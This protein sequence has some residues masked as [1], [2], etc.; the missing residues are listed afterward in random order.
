[1]IESH[2]S[3]QEPQRYVRAEPRSSS[4][5]NRMKNGTIHNPGCFPAEKLVTIVECANVAFPS[6]IIRTTQLSGVILFKVR[7]KMS[8]EGGTEEEKGS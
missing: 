7:K 5:C 8:E 3:T 1:M 6:S 4:P 2:C